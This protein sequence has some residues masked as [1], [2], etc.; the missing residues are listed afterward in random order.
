LRASVTS[1]GAPEISVGKAVVVEFDGNFTV[2]QALL[3]E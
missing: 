2:R 3:S 1:T